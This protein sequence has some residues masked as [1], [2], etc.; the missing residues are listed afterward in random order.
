MKMNYVPV[1]KETQF[2][3]EAF[4]CWLEL[5]YDRSFKKVA[6]L[7]G[8]NEN[9]VGT[10]AA[11]FDWLGRFEEWVLMP[12]GEALKERSDAKFK[13]EYYKEKAYETHDMAERAIYAMSHAKSDIDGLIKVIKIQQELDQPRKPGRPI[14]SRNKK[15]TKPK[16]K[17]I[18][19]YSDYLNEF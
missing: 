1:K 7:M 10:W 14:G 8:V 19:I 4:K 13:Y 15:G 17:R 12:Y 5:G 2:H 3:I 6:E 18:P 16:Y 9:T 11:S